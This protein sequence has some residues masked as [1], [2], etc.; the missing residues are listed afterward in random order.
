MF[1]IGAVLKIDDFKR[2][3]THPSIVLIGCIAQFTIMPIGAFILAKIFGL[4]SVLS[5]GLIMGMLASVLALNRLRKIYPLEVF[6]DYEALRKTL[7]RSEIEGRPGTM[8]RF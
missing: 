6:Y 5:I 8:W 4:S 3:L 1:G 7:R 2:I